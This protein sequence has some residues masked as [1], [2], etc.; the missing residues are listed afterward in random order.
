MEVRS[1]SDQ[2]VEV[3]QSNDR[4]LNGMAKGSLEDAGI[5]FW[6]QGGETAAHLGIGAV[7]FP[8]SRFLVPENREAEA[9]QLLDSWATPVTAVH[10]AEPAN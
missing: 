5:P 8:L 4:I 7:L 3:F 1:M 9:R 10:G 6:I 2:L